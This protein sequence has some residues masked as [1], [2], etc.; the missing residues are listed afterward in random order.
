MEWI[1]KVAQELQ[2][3]PEKVLAD[4]EEFRKLSKDVSERLTDSLLTIRSYR[5]IWA[6]ILRHWQYPGV[7]FSPKGVE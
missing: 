2:E 7:A 3:T 1:P 4:M 6:T 5:P